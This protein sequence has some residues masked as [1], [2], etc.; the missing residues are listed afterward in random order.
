MIFGV[1]TTSS[2]TTN[3]GYRYI[4]IAYTNGTTMT[5]YQQPT[6]SYTTFGIAAATIYDKVT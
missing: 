3:I 4:N 1:Y 6:P 2:S 5:V